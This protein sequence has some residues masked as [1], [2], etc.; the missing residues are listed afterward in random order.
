MARLA[1]VTGGCNLFLGFDVS[2][3]HQS[4]RVSF[5]YAIFLFLV[6]FVF[7]S[8]TGLRQGNRLLQVDLAIHLFGRGLALVR[9]CTLALFPVCFP[10]VHASVFHGG[11]PLSFACA[12]HDVIDLGSHPIKKITHFQKR[13]KIKFW[14]VCTK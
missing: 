8:C 14:K 11:V 12:L 3:C 13:L 2:F 6:P 5:L 9:K 7:S 10:L 1:K 4:F